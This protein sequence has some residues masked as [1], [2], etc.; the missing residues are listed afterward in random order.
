MAV[1]LALTPDLRRDVEVEGQVDA[2]RQAG[3]TSLGI[4]ADRAGEGARSTCGSAGMRC[5]EVLALVI[6]DNEEAT[7]A[8]AKRSADAAATMGASWVTTIFH[9]PI[10]ADT[11]ALVA[12][13]AAAIA[14]A[15]AGMA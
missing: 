12:R 13:C 11:P 4:F 5:H 1:E 9:S 10:N 3:F 8:S 2:A 6:T 15:G 7:L 14:D